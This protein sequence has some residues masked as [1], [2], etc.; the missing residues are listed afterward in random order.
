MR[1]LKHMQTFVMSLPTD[2]QRAFIYDFQTT[3]DGFPSKRKERKLFVR[4]GKL[5]KK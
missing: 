2:A 1:S 5:R 3:Y 4:T